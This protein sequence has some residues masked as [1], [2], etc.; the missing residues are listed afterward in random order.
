MFQHAYD[1]YMKYAYPYDE[2]RPLSCDGVDTWGSFSLTLI[3]A[4]DTLAIMGNY[5]EF[6]KVAAMIAENIN[7]NININVSVF[8][9]NIRV[10][11]GLLSAHLLSRKAQMPLEP[12]WP[13]SGPLLRLAE[14]VATRLLP[15][16]LGETSITC[17]AGVGTFLI[18]FATLSRLTGNPVFE[19]VAL[20]ALRAL[21]RS[22]TSIGLVGN[23]IDVQLGIWTATDSG[24]GAGVDSY[25]EY[26]VKGAIM[27]Q[28][29]ELMRMFKEY[30][31]TISKYMKRDD[32]YFWRRA[33]HLNPV[34]FKATCHLLISGFWI[35][36]PLLSYQLQTLI[37]DLDSA[38]KSL[39]NYHQVWKEYG[40]TPEFYEVVHGRAHPKRDG[41]PLR[42][43][44]T[45]K[46]LYLLFTPDHFIHNNGSSADIVQTSSGECII[47]TGAYVFN[48]EAHP[49]DVAAVHCCSA[50]K[51]SEDQ[52]LRDFAKEFD[53]SKL[54]VDEHRDDFIKPLRVKENIDGTDDT[55]D[56]EEPKCAKSETDK[57]LPPLPSAPSSFPAQDPALFFT[58]LLSSE[59][60][61]QENAQEGVVE[62]GD[63]EAGQ[64]DRSGD[65][66][67][68]ARMFGFLGEVREA[69]NDVANLETG[70][71]G[72]SYQ[73][74]LSSAGGRDRAVENNSEAPDTEPVISS[75]ENRFPSDLDS[76]TRNLTQGTAAGSP[77]S[78]KYSAA[79]TSHA[80]ELHLELPQ[81]TISTEPS[82][83]PSEEESTNPSEEE[84]T[85]DLALD[86][87][88]FEDEIDEYTSR[89][90]S[91]END[92]SEPD[93]TQ[94]TEESTELNSS[95]YVSTSQDVVKGSQEAVRTET[96]ASTT[97]G[98]GAVVDSGKSD[99]AKDDAKALEQGKERRVQ[100]SPS[101]ATF[102]SN[103]SDD[104]DTSTTTVVNA[105][106]GWKSEVKEIGLAPG[107]EEEVIIGD[108]NMSESRTSSE[109]AAQ[110][111][112]LLQQA[113]QEAFGK[114]SSVTTENSEHCVK[115]PAKELNG[116]LM[117]T[118]PSQPFT[119]RLAFRGEMFNIATDHVWVCLLTKM[120]APAKEAIQ[121]VQVF[122]RKK[123][124]TAVAYCK[125]GNGLLKVNGRPLENIEPLTL[126]YK[127]LEP[128]LLLGKERFAG[129]DIRIRVKGGGNVA[130]IYAIR[131]A[132]SKALVAYYQKYVDEQ[133]KK[134]I[135]DTL[136]QYDRTL[137]V[138]DPRRCEPK[139]F[140]G[141]GARARYQKSYR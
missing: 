78:T 31:K 64:E 33:P 22:R 92:N 53:L 98:D 24:I 83:D 79:E 56:S 141:P 21:W 16:P 128:I 51:A 67:N 89:H 88:E 131:Q 25:Y 97:V 36:F 91:A 18:E 35:D 86:E 99:G 17:T 73:P 103:G 38:R 61:A 112:G 68:D 100:S 30:E 4:L 135:K 117:L 110:S 12:G 116:W 5:T 108:T 13:C 72:G 90:P 95:K 129:V 127:L 105:T 82:I 107:E 66:D 3:D 123:T 8:E 44:E 76:E 32:W 111:E 113:L 115:K 102:G 118:C 15:V 140:G 121:S 55:D 132:I 71:A 27:L 75:D 2:L 93:D 7:F 49:V 101:E 29:P 122:G 137:L 58:D 40:F 23:H 104:P 80:G 59:K 119:S 39:Y 139:K 106:A 43:A 130:Q 57:N 94:P 50:D 48:T 138:A 134:E 42:P 62:V 6:R 46:Y 74:N 96:L 52:A 136:I 26:L 85:N 120:A 14:D 28:R 63:K 81:G 77:H 1:G 11:G 60:A 125:R 20:R 9:T 133:S 87:E 10:V 34:I 65:G 69:D 124:A 41:Y 84:S 109:V 45:T 70:E 54:L 37:G 19:Q 114:K 126:R 47:D